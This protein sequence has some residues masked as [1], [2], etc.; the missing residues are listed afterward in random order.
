MLTKDLNVLIIGLDKDMIRDRENPTY[1]RHR[2]YADEVSSLSFIVY[3]SRGEGFS[4]TLNGNFSV[5]PTNS[6]NKLTY[7]LDTLRLGKG[8]IKE[9][10][11]DVVV[12]QDPLATGLCGYILKKRI[13][14]VW[15][16]NVH[17]D[18]IDNPHWLVESPVNRVK[19]F[20]GK[21]MIKKA[22]GLRVVSRLIR[23]KMVRL[24]IAPES[25]V[26]ATPSVDLDKFPAGKFNKDGLKE[27]YGLK[28]KKVI[29]FVGRIEREK[30]IPLLLETMKR[31][32]DELPSAR[33]VVVGRGSLLDEMK[34]TA[35]SLGVDDRVN[36]TG[37][38]PFETL[39]D[40]YRL[41]DVFVLISYYEGTAKVLKEAAMAELP[42]IATDVSGSGE[43]VID[44]KNGY[45]IPV[46]DK[47]AL[48]RRLVE[49][50][51]ED[52]KAERMGRASKRHVEEAFNFKRNVGEIVGAWEKI[53]SLRR[54][55]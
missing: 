13:G 25:V 7:F 16:C 46:G 17:G 27:R 36:F 18:Y 44:G 40:Y 39:T 5:Y 28:G 47:G 8:I 38:L 32:K 4:E 24:G 55:I 50:L 29:L 45:L 19:N 2:A 6:A 15:V 30:E 49:L 26:H 3:T 9:K 10:G 31:L 54:K 52:R 34:K 35:G 42:I 21:F 48:Y 23:E 22:D 43:V 53:Y 37:H 20:V 12:T 14:I 1:R 11:I 51:S 41:S 33:L